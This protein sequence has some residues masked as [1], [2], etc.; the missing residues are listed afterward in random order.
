MWVALN[1]PEHTE[2]GRIDVQEHE[3][4]GLA[5]S[6]GLDSPAPKLHPNEDAC[7]V[8]AGERAVAVVADAHWGAASAVELVRAFGQHGLTREAVDAAA[9]ALQRERS[10]CAWLA[11]EVQGRQVRWWSQGDCRLYRTGLGVVNPLVPAYFGARF[12]IRGLRQG[13]FQLAE[14]ERVVL[15]SDGLPECIYGEPTLDAA[16]VIA[17]VHGP[18][19]E[20]ARRLVELALAG[21]GE[22]NIAVVV[23][24]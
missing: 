15:A 23:S 6:K 16:A 9:I 4:W 12:G 24:P 19:D 20:V 7:G 11:V 1:G 8:S 17:Q 2:P 5:I 18:A 3:G 10:E 21:G 13:I 14:G 22:D